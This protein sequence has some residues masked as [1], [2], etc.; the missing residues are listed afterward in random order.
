MMEEPIEQRG[1]GGGIAEQL[2]PVV[3][4]SIRRQQG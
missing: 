3:H 4:R 2:T 1:D